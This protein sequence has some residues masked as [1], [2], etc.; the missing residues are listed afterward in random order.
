M[1]SYLLQLITFGTVALALVVPTIGDRLSLPARQL[2]SVDTTSGDISSD[3]HRKTTKSSKKHKPNSSGKKSAKKNTTEKS[4][5]SSKS[6][7]KKQQKSTRDPI[8]KDRKSNKKKSKEEVNR[9]DNETPSNP[10]DVGAPSS[11]PLPATLPPTCLECDDVAFPLRSSSASLNNN[12]LGAAGSRY[13]D[14]G[15]GSVRNV[16]YFACSSLLVLII[17]WVA[18]WVYCSRRRQHKLGAGAIQAEDDDTVLFEGED[19][20]SADCASE[21]KSVTS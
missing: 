7:K 11:A 6:S 10:I 1:K 16:A 14:S 4:S 15:P 12:T 9:G 18:F 17:L 3:I 8:E 13:D 2:A 21:D 19:D 5:K 20:T